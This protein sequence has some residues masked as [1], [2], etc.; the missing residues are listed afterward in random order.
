[1]STKIYKV[2]IGSTSKDL[3]NYREA[4]AEIC[5]RVD[6]KPV[7]METFPAMDMG[8]TAGSLA[9]LAEADVYVGIFGY[10]YGYIENKDDGRGVTEIE[11]D[12]AGAKK[13]SRLCFVARSESMFD[14]AMFDPANRAKLDDFHAKVKTEHIVDFFDDVNDF[15]VKLMQALIEWKQRQ[16]GY[17]P[18]SIVV[19]GKLAETPDDL[20]QEMPS[21]LLGR[22][23]IMA[24]VQTWLANG[25]KILLHGF[26]GMGKTALAATAA[27]HFLDGTGGRK[28]VWARIRSQPA[29]EVMVGLAH[30]FGIDAVKQMTVTA[31]EHKPRALRELLKGQGVNLLVLD[32]AWDGPALLATLRAIP[33]SLPVL[34]TSRHR[35]PIEG[36]TAPVGQLSKEGAQAVLAHY[37][38]QPSLLND[39]AAA[40]LCQTVGY[41][42]FAIEI[43][44]KTLKADGIPPAV[45]EKRIH[46]TPHTLTMPLDYAEPERE[47]VAKLLEASLNELDAD[48]RRVF[49]A[50]GA[51]FVPSATP[52]LLSRFLNSPSLL[53]GEGDTGGED[54][55][56]AL[57]TLVRRGLAD[58]IPETDEATAKYQVHDLAQSYARAQQPPDARSR[59][60]QV[61]L[62]YTWA[63]NKPALPNF[64]ALVPEIDQFVAASQ[65]AMSRGHLEDVERFAWNLYVNSAVLQ[66]RGFP[67][68]AVTLLIFAAAAA[69][70]QGNPYNQSAHLNHLGLAYRALGEVQQAIPYYEQALA[71]VREIENRSGEAALLG[72]LGNAYRDLGDVQQAIPYFEQ[73][74]VISHEIGDKMLEG[75]VLGNLGN[76]YANLG[77]VQQAISYY[78]Q[79]LAIAREIGDKAD[80]GRHLGNL[81]IAYSDLGEIPK[82]IGYYEQGLAIARAI[83]DKMSEGY[84]LNSLGAAYENL[85][86]YD[87]AMSYFR[88]ALAIFEA[89]GA[90]PMIKTV[91]GNIA[92]TERKLRGK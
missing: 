59:A 69:E 60:L 61:C 77:E 45:L 44:G 49:M 70:Q 4:A 13:V 67:Q 37:A 10:R 5:D 32:D 50:F 55:V 68:Q 86:E 76:A 83:G 90:K 53:G 65:W 80:E 84:R 18:I 3:P 82:A 21:K 56:S 29:G 33:A 43:A 72:S 38:G 51:F 52:E 57:T 41:H 25:D 74:L 1:M 35:Y 23:T 64:K 73:A 81:G 11:F 20:K 15:R 78:E 40:A 27:A 14:P 6:M 28:V 87:R 9:K 47:S 24:D 88:P 89:I 19:R 42:A 75:Q 30:A 79:S 92:I 46:D 48:S 85:G 63:Y 12:E 54:V 26:G 17:E 71:I 31:D 2:F 91:S 22:D 62:D 66:Y 16:I 8:A 39:P 7:H 36:Q 58:Y 34:V